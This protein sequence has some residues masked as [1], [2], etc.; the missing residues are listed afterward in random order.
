MESIS[1]KYIL[2]SSTPE[3]NQVFDQMWGHIN[4]KTGKQ[5]EQLFSDYGYNNIIYLG[6]PTPWTKLF[7]K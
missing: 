3:H 2:F 5:W 1:P 4:I 7:Y 6:N